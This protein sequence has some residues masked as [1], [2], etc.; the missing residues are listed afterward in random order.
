MTTA[1]RAL[2]HRRSQTIV[3][4]VVI[5]VLSAIAATAPW[6]PRMVRDQTTA[7]SF[8]VGQPGGHIRI[9]STG[10]EVP[11]ELVP[12][13]PRIVSQ[14]QSRDATIVWST[15][16]V[17][18]PGEGS[19]LTR[20]GICDHVRFVEGGCP[21]TGEQVAISATDRDAWQ[22]RPGSRI[23][24][25]E[26][27]GDQEGTLTVSGVYEVSDP[28]EP[29][30]YGLLPTGRSGYRDLEIPLTDQFLALPALWE[31]FDGF[32]GTSHLDVRVDG[33]NLPASDLD[34]LRAS[35]DAL[36]ARVQDD[37]LARVASTLPATLDGLEHSFSV[38]GRGIAL[39]VGQ[40]AAIGIVGLLIVSL[41][42]VR[43]RRR[44]IGLQ[45]LRGRSPAQLARAAALEWAALAVPS[46][47]LGVIA[48]GVFAW[49][50]KA[51][52][53][54]AA[55]VLTPPLLALLMS[56]LVLVGGSLLV[57]VQT[58]RTAREPIP[59][60]LRATEE[61][62]ASGRSA[63]AI[64]DV[65]LL[66]VVGSAVLVAL[67]SSESSLLVLLT[68]A[69]LALAG[70]VLASRLAIRV[71]AARG[72]R[73]LIR[74]PTSGL[75]AVEIARGGGLRSALMVSG[76]ATALM[77]LTTQAA[78][79]GDHNRTHRAEV[80]TGAATVWS[81]TA[82][83][84]RV[85]TALDDVDPDRR[86]AT[87]V[88][89]VERPNDGY[90]VM[91]VEP[92]AFGR[93]A[94]GTD[95]ALPSG[96]WADLEAAA[97]GETLLTG[98][99]LRVRFDGVVRST[100]GPVQVWATVADLSGPTHPLL[101]GDLGAGR[102]P[103]HLAVRAPCADGCRLLNLSFRPDGVTTMKGA[104]TLES[105]DRGGW[106][107]V[108]LRPD[109]FAVEKPDGDRYRLDVSER[110]DTGLDLDLAS[111]G[112]RLDLRSTWLSAA[113]P[114]LAAEDLAVDIE[115]G[116]TVRTPDGDSLPVTVV[117][118]FRDATPRA[119]ANVLV[120]DLEIPSR[121]GRTHT[122]PSTRT[123][124]WVGPDAD[125]S[126]L[127][128]GLA[129]HRVEVTELASLAE[130]T[131]RHDNT[132]E[133]LASRL[134]PIAAA[135][136]ALLAAGCL[137]LTVA[138]GRQRRTSDLRALDLAGVAPDVGARATRWSLLVPVLAGV[139][140]GAVAGV[141]GSRFAVR[142][143]PIFADEEPS[144]HLQLGLHP[145]AAALTVTG[146]GVLLVVVILL[147]ARAV[148]PSGREPR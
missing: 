80:E 136:V 134:N 143:L 52:W 53:L 102:G 132:A 32:E 92:D 8:A 47:L 103:R 42:G 68:P 148:V 17:S 63:L 50:V 20:D 124:V 99:E 104:F 10:P 100:G 72:Q 23:D 40:L 59:A 56:A 44:D 119:V 35:Y 95:E 60:L 89:S 24:F 105:R 120:A 125:L 114:V 137:V 130:A 112:L 58:W 82:N 38:A 25:Q 79:I 138:G 96:N 4:V 90:S 135:L 122:D 141:V 28:T 6:Y 84:L 133:A 66:A 65:T 15:A 48:A 43:S 93:I 21:T 111:G 101:L 85:R 2:R 1:L 74:R 140:I 41:L 127:R 22:L 12:E 142:G 98:A 62:A 78:L 30:W 19:V 117:D 76:V 31:S 94:L 36:A 27:T 131:A 77:V 70:G 46:T 69:L 121:Y 81:T 115:D 107:S 144:I 49:A 26:K 116:H 7:V 11:A 55:S 106:A 97:G 51:A 145:W 118:R 113:L 13:D 83:P 73:W 64:L 86:Q 129:Q 14:V 5:A 87:V 54:P 16:T 34:E 18:E 61:R 126:A 3:T 67:T 33:A 71:I 123:T 146:A 45:R 108:P 29:Y 147:A 39:T 91:Y 75:A 110:P 9:D 128:D 57:G 109:A 139:A 88:A 37:P